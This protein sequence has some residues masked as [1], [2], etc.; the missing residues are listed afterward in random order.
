MDVDWSGRKTFLLIIALTS[1]AFILWLVL[2]VLL[3]AGLKSFG[4]SYDLWAMIE[5]IS[6]AL[7]TAAGFTAGFIAYW[8]LSEI[9]NTRFMEVAGSSCLSNP[10]GLD[11]RGT[12]NA[13]D[14]P[15]ERQIMGQI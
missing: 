15:H 13:L 1:G 11:R 14:E 7:A 4:A 12:G 9:S 8:E 10:I 6:T 2:L 3:W 5:A